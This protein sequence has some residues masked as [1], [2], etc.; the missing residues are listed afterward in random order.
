MF[1][2]H[3]WFDQKPG[4]VPI[5]SFTFTKIRFGH[6]QISVPKIGI[7]MSKTACIN[8]TKLSLTYL[9]QPL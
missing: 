6:A 1:R 5:C 8:P 4:T 7:Q 2:L 3:C 9:D